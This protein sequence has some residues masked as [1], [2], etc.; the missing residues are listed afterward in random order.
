MT[1]GATGAG[2]FGLSFAGARLLANPSVGASVFSVVAAGRARDA[3]PRLGITGGVSASVGSDAAAGPASSMAGAAAATAS[4]SGASSAA[5]GLFYRRRC[6]IG[7]RRGIARFD[8][9]VR[10][11]LR[12]FFGFRIVLQRRLGT[13]DIGRILRIV[14]NRLRLFGNLHHRPVAD[15]HIADDDNGDPVRLDLFAGAE[16]LR[17]VAGGTKERLP[18]IGAVPGHRG[19]ADRVEPMFGGECL[20]LRQRVSR[21]TAATCVRAPSVLR[22]KARSSTK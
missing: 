13:V 16:Q 8:T 18:Q 11:G 22:S 21:A 20:R 14:R 5:G 19:K 3:A 4:G 10:D 2:S 1:G 6:L 7:L 12:H 17:G 15:V 9:F